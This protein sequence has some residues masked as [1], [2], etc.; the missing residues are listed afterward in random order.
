MRGVGMQGIGLSPA[1]QART[2]WLPIWFVQFYQENDG[3]NFGS[4]VNIDNLFN[5][6]CTIEGYFQ[7]TATPTA[8]AYPLSKNNG[9][10]GN[11]WRMFINAG[12]VV[13]F[14]AFFGGVNININTGA[15]VLRLRQWYHIAVDFDVGTLTAR[16][17]IDGIPRAQG[18]AV[19]A[20]QADAANNLICNGVLNVGIVDDYMKVGPIRLSSARRYT[21]ASFTPP[22]YADWPANDANAQLITRMMDKTGAIATDYSGNGY[23]GAITFGVNTRWYSEPFLGVVKR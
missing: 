2:H 22:N 9:G 21:G 12:L 17:C 20:Y 10:A 11:G 6:D 13:N 1:I 3:I 5:A 14:I 19:G 18:I 4:G 16:L 15:F 23:N 8:V 7:V